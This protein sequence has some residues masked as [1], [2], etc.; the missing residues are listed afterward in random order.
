MPFS[1]TCKAA[2]QKTVTSLCP[3]QFQSCSARSVC[4][5]GFTLKRSTEGCCCEQICPLN[6]SFQSCGVPT[7]CLTT[8]ANLKNPPTICPAMCQTGCYC[9]LGLIKNAKGLC[10]AP[11]NCPSNS[12]GV[13][14]KPN[15]INP[16]EPTCD[17][18]S[19]T[20]CPTLVCQPG[21]S[22]KKGFVRGSDGTCVAV[23]QCP[24]TVQGE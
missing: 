4:K 8:C 10:V 17:E 11:Y 23:D 2:A 19:K 7:S 15:C 24:S 20:P 21:C 18:P 13:N 16:C 9:N 3:Y 6:Q 22:C 5:N 12:C 1:A 14:E